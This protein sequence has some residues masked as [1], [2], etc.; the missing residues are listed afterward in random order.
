MR[1][2]ARC[3]L[4][5]GIRR[6]G[7]APERH[8]VGIVHL[9]LGAFH[10]AHQ[11]VY[12]DDALALHGGDWRIRGISL[13]SGTVAEQLNPQDGR[14][15]VVER[16]HAHERL[17]AIG[18]VA[19]VIAAPAD[20]AGA[21]EAIAAPQTAILSL[22]VT[23]KGYADPRTLDLIVD[24]LARRHAA[25][26]GMPTLLSCDNLPDNGRTLRAAVIAH[27]ALRD[28]RLA[29]WIEAEG[30]FPSTMVDRIVPAT[31]AS[32]IARLRGLTGIE[33]RGMVKTEPFTQWVIEDRFAG[34]RPAFEQVGAQLVNDV[35]PFELA[36]LRMLNG[37]HSTLAYLGLAAGFCYVHEAIGDAHLRAVIER[38]MREEA[39]STLPDDPAL[40]PPR[41]ADALIARF[42]NPALEHRLSQI[43]MDGTQKLPQ[44]L[45]GTIRDRL[46]Q[47]RPARAALLGLAGWVAHAAGG[48]VDDPRAEEIAAVARRSG[49]D[50]ETLARGL[51]ALIDPGLAARGSV[52]AELARDV[53]ALRANARA[54]LAAAA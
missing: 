52:M 44:R 43:A 17:R 30:A 33:D 25:G 11:A 21:V 50:P 8:G 20:R 31:T 23:E 35:R 14:Y 4:P 27:A 1:L 6:P 24:G 53:A 16:D 19:G 37:A 2:S 46:A 38:L 54:R 3:T 41:Y 48:A 26:V 18:A 5:A 12:V 34:A 47:G 49:G 42:A 29:R 36:K 22:T 32:D 10:R 39:A 28:E 9:G 13:R 51:V 45:L 40:D 15:L 7:Y